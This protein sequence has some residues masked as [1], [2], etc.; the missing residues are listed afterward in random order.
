MVSIRNTQKML[1]AGSMFGRLA[2][3]LVVLHY[4]GCVAAAQADQKPLDTSNGYTCVHPP[5]KI[6]LVSKSPLVIYI[7]DFLTA[8]ERQHLQDSS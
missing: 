3:L 2:Q 4:A 5:Y 8:T 6:H 7:S 1:V